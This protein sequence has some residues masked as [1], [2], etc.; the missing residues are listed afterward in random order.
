[1]KNYLRNIESDLKIIAD[2]IGKMKE[3][4]W[5]ADL[6]GEELIRK[7]EGLSDQ[8]KRALSGLALVMGHVED[9]DS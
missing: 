4:L 8:C 3:K 9:K 2:E 7:H 5:L 6:E 1:M